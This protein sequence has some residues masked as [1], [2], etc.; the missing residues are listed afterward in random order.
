MIVFSGTFTV[1]DSAGVAHVF[2][3]GEQKF[4]LASGQVQGVTYSGLIDW[5]DP[6]SGERFVCNVTDKPISASFTVQ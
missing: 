2:T 6:V 5:T 3:D 1:T 4:G